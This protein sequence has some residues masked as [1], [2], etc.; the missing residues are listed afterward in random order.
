MFQ[1]I[2][3]FLSTAGTKATEVLN[4]LTARQ[5]AD[6]QKTA[7]RAAASNPMTWQKYAPWIIGG[8]LLIGGG[9]LLASR[10]GR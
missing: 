3:D 5:Q 1:K 10:R 6:N 7:A 2:T 8:V 4:S 9:L